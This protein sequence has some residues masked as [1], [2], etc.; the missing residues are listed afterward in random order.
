M[1]A[2]A[3]ELDSARADMIMFRDRGDLL[4]LQNKQLQH[5]LEG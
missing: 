5:D 3:L 2:M 1:A 4:E